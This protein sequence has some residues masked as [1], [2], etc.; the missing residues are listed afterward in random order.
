MMMWRM[1]HMCHHPR[2][3]LMAEERALVVAVGQQEMNKLRKKPKKIMMMGMTKC[4]M[5]RR[6]APVIC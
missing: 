1:E 2:L 4:L 3:I 6:S 5:L